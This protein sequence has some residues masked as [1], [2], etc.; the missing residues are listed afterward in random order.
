MNHKAAVIIC[1]YNEGDIIRQCLEHWKEIGKDCIEFYLCDNGSTDDT[2]KI[3]R[4]YKAKQTIFRYQETWDNH[5][6]VNK[7]KDR[8][9]V[10]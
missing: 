4:E 9:S 1:A 7:M 6:V 8:K 5:T 3:M 10:V 2:W